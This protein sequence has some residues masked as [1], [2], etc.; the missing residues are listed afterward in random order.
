MA[1]ATGQI[2]IIDLNDAVTL[3][4]YLNGSKAN[5][6]AVDVGGTVF[7]PSWF[8]SALVITA[9]LS[10]MGSGTNIISDSEVGPISWSY[11]LGSGVETAIASLGNAVA[12]GT[13]NQVLTISDNK[14]TLANPSI[15]LIATFVYTHPTLGA[16]TYKMDISYMLQKQGADGA[17]GGDAYTVDIRK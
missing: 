15:K 17:A 16:L 10:K 6:Q 3:Q 13:N 12:T 8:T 9:T 2:T 14:M 4:G 7:T 5:G 11:I 1:V